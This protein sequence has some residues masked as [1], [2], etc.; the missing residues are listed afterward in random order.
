MVGVRQH[1]LGTQ[2]ADHLGGQCLNVCLRTDGDERGGANITVRGMNDAGSSQA[3][4]RFQTC[5]DRK[6]AVRAVAARRGRGFER[7]ELLSSGGGEPVV[8]HRSKTSSFFSPSVRRMAAIT[9]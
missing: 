1:C 8:L 5:A 4:V 6:S 9:G 7:R 3:S 2:T